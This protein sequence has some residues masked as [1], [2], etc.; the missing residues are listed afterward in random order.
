MKHNIA[1]AVIAFLIGSVI[2]GNALDWNK[3]LQY[4]FQS[5]EPNTS[6]VLQDDGQGVYIKRWGLTNAQPTKAELQAVEAQAIAW[7]TDKVKNKEADFEN[8]DRP[9]LVAFVKV[10]MDEI[11]L[12]RAQHGLAPRTMAQLKAAIKGKL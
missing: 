1:T 11:N 8:W 9:E 3:C 10:M 12:L 7:Y 2:S 4:K 6:W 5:A